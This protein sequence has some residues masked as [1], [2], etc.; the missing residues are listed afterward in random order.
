M[1]LITVLFSCI[2]LPS[3]RLFRTAACAASFQRDYLPVEELRGCGIVDGT[4]RQSV[5]LVPR[6]LNGTVRRLAWTSKE[7]EEKKCDLEEEKETEESKA[8]WRQR[9]WSTVVGSEAEAEEKEKEKE[10]ERNGKENEVAD[11]G[12]EIGDASDEKAANVNLHKDAP[13]RDQRIPGSNGALSKAHPSATINRSAS[14][15]STSSTSASA[16]SK[17]R[18]SVH[19]RHS[20][21]RPASRKFRR[22]SVFYSGISRVFCLRT[23]FCCCGGADHKSDKQ[24]NRS[25]S[26]AGL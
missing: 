12:K 16:N 14:P 6:S 24:L 25:N 22:S 26:K 15:L 1:A 10:T 4:E 17:A 5:P 8:M 9:A 3:G 19:R 23:I 21:L 20:L 2:L 7:D 18:S 11:W 13:S